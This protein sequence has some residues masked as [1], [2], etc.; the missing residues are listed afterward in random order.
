M[1]CWPKYGLCKIFLKT[2]QGLQIEIQAVTLKITSF[3]SWRN[4][5]FDEFGN[6]TFYA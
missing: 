2:N 3:E 4:V 5:F 1:G 6:S